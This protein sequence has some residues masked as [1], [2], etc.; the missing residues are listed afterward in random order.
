MKLSVALER[1]AIVVASLALSF[2]LIALLSG[3]FAG[4]D[5]AGIS[6]TTVPV[7]Q[8]F[9]DQGNKLLQPGELHPGYDS[10]PPTSG[11]HVYDVPTRDQTE[12]TDDQLLTALASGDV[13]IMYGSA[14]PPKDLVALA[15]SVAPFS[16]ALAAAGESV[17]LAR[18]PGISGLVALAWG[19]MARVEDATDPLL[20]EFIEYWMGRG[21][22]A[23]PSH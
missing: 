8:Q 4:R 21:A 3:F 1:V 2:G 16:P 17:I 20:K 18:K 19:H 10:D 7:G 22:P 11:A 14:T 12:L 9:H 23:A 6:I 15:Q 13:V 5:Q